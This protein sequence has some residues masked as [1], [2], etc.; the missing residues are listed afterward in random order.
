[1]MIN[2]ISFRG[3]GNSIKGK[4]FGKL[5][6]LLYYELCGKGEMLGFLRKSGDQKGCCEVYFISTPLFGPPALLL[7][8]EFRLILFNSI[9]FQ[10]VIQNFE[11]VGE[12]LCV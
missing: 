2:I 4:T 10:F 6:A 5:L 8:E 11:I 1:M 12:C 9:D 3:L 7:L